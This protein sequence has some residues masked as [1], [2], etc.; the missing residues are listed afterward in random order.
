MAKLEF[1]KLKQ[2]LEKDKTV[3]VF[4]TNHQQLSSQHLPG[5]PEHKEETNSG[6][7]Y[8]SEGLKR[9]LI[10]HNNRI[11]PFLVIFVLSSEE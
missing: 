10:P 7:V 5:F 9:K 6:C 11:T 4:T 8:L 2:N 1:R 3:Q